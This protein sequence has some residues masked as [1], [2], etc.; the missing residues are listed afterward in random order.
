MQIEIQA[1]NFPLSKALRNHIER[2]LAFAVS[3]WSEHIQRILVRLSDTNGPRGGIDKCCHIQVIL[4]HQNDVVI[5][6]TEVD[7][8]VAIDRAAGRAARTVSRRMT[9]QRTRERSSG[10]Q[11]VPPIYELDKQII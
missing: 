3:T 2:R 10:L 11:P 7:L 5:E 1:R 6:D 9:R 8:Y 4:K